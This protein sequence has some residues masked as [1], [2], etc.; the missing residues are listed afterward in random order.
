MTPSPRAS[1]AG[2]LIAL[3]LIYAFLAGFH[4]TDFDTGWHLATGRYVLQH[5]AIPSTDQF[6]YTARGAEWIYPPF[7]GIIFYLLYQLAGF[8]AIS[9]LT[10]A[11]CVLAVAM[12]V[13]RDQPM[14]AALAII[15]VPAIAFRTVA[16]ADLFTTVL[17]AALL[18]V[19]W[20]YYRGRRVRLW[21][22]PLIMLCWAN[23]HPGFVAGLGMIFAYVGLETL[24]MLA[25]HDRR[26]A[27]ITRLRAAW[28]WLIA[29]AAATLLNP[30]GPR[31]YRGVLEQPV[32]TKAWNYMAGDLA[33]APLWTARN[34]LDWRDPHTAY[35][36]LIVIAAIALVIA[37]RK[38]EFGAAALL[39]AATYVSF[40][41]VRYQAM[42]AIVVVVV[43]GDIFSRLRRPQS[44]AKPPDVRRSRIAAA[45]PIAFACL[46]AALT[47]GRCAD[48][49]SNRSYITT[50]EVSLFGAEPSW[51][52]PQRAAEFVRREHLPT[53]LFNEFN[54][55]SY[56]TWALP[57]YPV[58]SDNRGIPFGLQLLFH[59]RWLMQQPPDSEAWSAEADHWG[60]NTLLFSVARYGGLGSF[61][62]PE[63]CGSH[64]WVPVY[65]DDVAA[66]FLRN[67]PENAATI[68]RLR[69]NCATVA[70]APAPG[71]RSKAEE[72]EFYANAGAILYLL[73]RDAEAFAALNR[74]GQLF[75]DEAGVHLTRGQ[76]FQAS[77]RFADAEREYRAALGI[78]ETSAAW[79]TLGMLLEG[80]K[81][82]PEAITALEHAARLDVYPY[83]TYVRLGRMYLITSQPDAALKAFD[84]AEK[85]SPFSGAASS[86]AEFYAQLADGRAEAYKRLGDLK[87]AVES[88]QVSVQW[89]PASANRWN[90]LADLYQ[91]SGQE[92]LAQQARMRAHDLSPPTH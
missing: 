26:H 16:R 84:R 64:E 11:A 89:S 62:L 63:F 2:A 9:W 4:T 41:R 15:A 77:R 23:L 13:R 87:R 19:I 1:L 14:T 67:R 49:I 88:A 36:W 37:V 56:L 48:L 43:A 73:G 31:L 45:L 35:W 92:Q 39:A 65:L 20:S 42:F 17:F 33:S 76:L 53:N 28:P 52:Y 40:T 71:A 58:Y 82:W 54:V 47:L 21:L 51:V 22:V 8:S 44:L 38:K 34:A 74:A 85:A 68:E 83:G 86:N 81:R 90:K 91:A 61:P 78:R 6:S 72:F 5:H 66:V 27:A 79:F 30:W 25:G 3:A 70:L 55:G 24:E 32:V 29:G 12:T 69:I 18:R 46:L 57:E 75:P 60:I 80:E 10:A 59:Q 7:T 50:A